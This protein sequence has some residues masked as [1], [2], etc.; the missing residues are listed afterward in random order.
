M[1]AGGFAIGVLSDTK[2]LARVVPLI[3]AG[4]ALGCTVP[5]ALAS[6]RPPIT[7]DAAAEALTRAATCPPS[8]FVVPARDEAT[9]LRR[10][11]SDISRQDLPGVRRIAALMSLF[12]V[13][14]RSTDG[15]A[16]AVAAAAADYDIAAVTRVVARPWPWAF[17]MAKAQP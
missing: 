3:T 7:S 2:R 6:R 16:D 11:M 13:D 1:L 17:Q 4:V 8:A 14:D 15:T 10:L 9:V 5:V 12:V